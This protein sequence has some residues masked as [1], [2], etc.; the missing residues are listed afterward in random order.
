MPA[1]RSISFDMSC[2]KTQTES[3]GYRGSLYYISAKSAQL[4]A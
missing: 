4:Y 3:R 2:K 1:G